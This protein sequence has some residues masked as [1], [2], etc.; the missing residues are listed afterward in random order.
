M[1]QVQRM[2]QA[3]LSMKKRLMADPNVDK[4]TAM[5]LYRMLDSEDDELIASAIEIMDLFG[6]GEDY[7][8]KDIPVD[9]MSHEL[10]QAGDNLEI[11]YRDAKRIHKKRFELRD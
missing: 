11:G 10:N 5:K 3:P 7:A 1:E 2:Y 9:D 4:A 6:Y 8:T